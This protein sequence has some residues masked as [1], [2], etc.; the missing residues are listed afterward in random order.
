MGDGILTW[1]RAH[2][3]HNCNNRESNCKAFLSPWLP[4][5]RALH[6]CGVDSVNQAVSLYRSDNQLKN[7]FTA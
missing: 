7:G 1:K 6:A 2:E 4:N 3:K 5:E